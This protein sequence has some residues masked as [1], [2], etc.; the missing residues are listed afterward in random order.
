[1]FLYTKNNDLMTNEQEEF[2]TLKD[3]ILDNSE[4]SNYNTGSSL[5]RTFEWEHEQDVRLGVTINE[6]E[7]QFEFWVELKSHVAY[8]GDESKELDAKEIL[9]E[10]EK[11]NTDIS[12]FIKEKLISD[13]EFMKA[14]ETK[15]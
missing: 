2:D 4:E 7:L 5:V 9:E 13:T 8:F 11:I 12:D 6:E 1:M 10:M 15:L 3:L 14:I